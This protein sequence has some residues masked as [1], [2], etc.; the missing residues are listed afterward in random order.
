[1]IGMESEFKELIIKEIEKRGT[2]KF[3][4]LH[5]DRK[6]ITQKTVP[7]RHIQA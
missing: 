6:A 1:M 2:K 3:S 5:S 7:S 4:A